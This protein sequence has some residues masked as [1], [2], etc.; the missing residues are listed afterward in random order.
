[1]GVK[2]DFFKCGSFLVGDSTTTRFWEDSWL[3][4]SPS[5]SQYPSIYNTISHKNVLAVDVL[6]RR[7]LNIGFTQVLSNDKWETQIRSVWRLREFISR[8]NQIV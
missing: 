4:N 2:K 6:Q 1:M 7:P 3:S 8:M 5:A